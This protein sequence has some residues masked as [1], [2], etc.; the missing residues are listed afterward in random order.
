MDSG[1]QERD[2]ER[3]HMHYILASQ[4][5]F[6]VPNR[7]R[8]ELKELFSIRWAI[9]CIRGIFL[10]QIY[11]SIEYSAIRTSAPCHPW[12]KWFKCFKIF[13]N[14]GKC[15]C[16]VYSDLCEYRIHMFMCYSVS[17]PNSIH[18]ISFHSKS[19]MG[20]AYLRRTCNWFSPHTKNS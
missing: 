10:R 2:L 15:A 16:L 12:P 6:V 3:R 19:K 13:L 9:G 5:S 20:S 1:M 14:S 11:F 18:Y 17:S 7:L 4:P 8:E